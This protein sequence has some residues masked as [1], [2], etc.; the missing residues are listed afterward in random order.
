M[1]KSL[2][3]VSLTGAVLTLLPVLVLAQPTGIT[4][5]RLI[6]SVQNA[7]WKVFGVVALVCFVIAGFLFLTSAGDPEKIQAAKHAFF[8]GIAGV[9]VGILAWSIIALISGLL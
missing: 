8:W 9:V 2:I 6:N 7:A 3:V 4:L 1:K 5:D